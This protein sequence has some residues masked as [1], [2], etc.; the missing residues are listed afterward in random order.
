M[1]PEEASRVC[2]PNVTHA[3]CRGRRF[4]GGEGSGAGALTPAWTLLPTACVRP[5]VTQ[6]Q[7]LTFKTCVLVILCDT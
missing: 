5:R 7:L 1:A 4:A 3:D 2:R 6:G